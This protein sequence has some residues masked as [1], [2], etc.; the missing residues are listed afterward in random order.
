MGRTKKIPEYKRKKITKKEHRRLLNLVAH[1]N[2][3]RMN[4]FQF[5]A[6]I[7]EAGR[8]PMAGPV[9]AASCIIPAEVY[10]PGVNDSKQLTPEE[11]DDL[12]EI[13]SKDVR[14]HYGI[15]VIS[16]EEIDRVNIYQAAMLAMLQSLA[17][18]DLRPD[19][20]LVDGL[21][22]QHPEILCEKIIGGDALSQSIAAASIL[23]KVTRDRIMKEYHK[24][25]PLYGFDQHKGYCTHQHIE[26]LIKF[27]PCQI[28]RRS[29]EPVYDDLYSLQLY[30][31]SLTNI[32]YNCMDS[33]Q[34]SLEDL[35]L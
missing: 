16:H 34:N 2:A 22:L 13:I 21:H 10:F 24:I 18:L 30:Y 23:A 17:N 26:A 15:G 28:H 27:G 19:F 29:F 8:G 5:I 7:D 14:I 3:A 9:V 6:G 1:E 12:F 4:G 11:R 31:N 32:E 20:L 35:A 33:S 25:W